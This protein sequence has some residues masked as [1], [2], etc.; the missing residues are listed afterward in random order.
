MDGE[1]K[2]VLEYFFTNTDK[3]IFAVKNLPASVQNYIY[4][5]VSRFP[6][7][8]ERFLK[9]LREKGIFERVAEA[10]KNKDRLDILME[11]LVKHTAER[12]VDMFFKM[13]HKSSAEGASAFVV[14]EAN[15]IYATENQQDFYYPMTTMEFSTRYAR[16]FDI[17]HV[18]W[19]PILMKSKYAKDIKKVTARNFELYTNGFEPL[20]KFFTE[21]Q[22]KAELPEKV[23][24]LDSLRFLIPISAYTTI[25]L[26]GNTRSIMEH[27]G[28][29]LGSEDTFIK[30]YAQ[31]SLKELQQV[32]P[33][34]FDGI[35]ADPVVV[36]RNKKLYRLADEFFKKKFKPVKDDLTMHYEVP[37]EELAMAQIVY[38]FCNVPFADVLEK[39]SSLKPSERLELFKTANEGRQVRKNPIR[40]F[41]TRPLVYEVEAPWALWKDF[42][43]NRM[44]LRFHQDMRG[45]AGFDTPP[46]IAESEL[47]NDYQQ[48]QKATCELLEKVYQDYGFRA[49]AAAS[50]GC[51][52]RFLLTMGPRQLTVLT[53]LRTCGEGDKG[54]RKI[55][56]RMVQ[57]AKE[58]NPRLYGHIIDSYRGKGSYEKS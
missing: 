46:L 39:V 44:N 13:G 42:K 52:K 10:I 18:Y 34:F 23:S 8:R 9:L 31:H 47:N 41:E 28:K 51:R 2:R 3:P 56:S 55:A 54:Y 24:V 26:G 4:A 35:T 14:S 32:V 53:E 40:G 49:R 30:D 29:M 57:M 15:P 27:F 25:I 37:T 58:K 5:G 50:Q 43:R 17:D 6:S 12:N 33:G 1:E 20:M 48:A 22:E 21:K 7:V 11:P 45:L 16:K 19:D 38:P 36:E